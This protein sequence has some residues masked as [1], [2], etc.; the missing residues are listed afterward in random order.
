M[1]PNS[2]SIANVTICTGTSYTPPGGSAETTSGTYITQITNAAGCDSTITTNLL[3]ITASSTSQNIEICKGGSATLP[4]MTVVSPIVNTDYTTTYSSINVPGCDSVITTHVIV[5]QLPVLTATASQIQCT[6]TKGSV[7][8]SASNGT[9]SYTYGGSPTLNLSAGTYNYNVTD[10]KGC[11]GT[12]SATINPAP[13]PL[14][15]SSTTSQISC[16]GNKGSVSLS[17]SGGVSPYV[18]SGSNS[19]NLTAGTYNYTVTD[20]VG[21]SVNLSATINPAPPQLI[22]TATATQIACYLG[23]GSVALSTTGGTPGYVLSGSPTTN[24]STGT[25]NYTVTDSK[26]CTATAFAFIAPAPA[27]L[28]GATSST[29]TRCDGT[30]GTVSITATGGSA[31]YTFLWNTSPAQTTQQAT[32]LGVGTYSVKITD[33]HGCTATASRAVTKALPTTISITGKNT[34]CP[35]EPTSLCATTGLVSYLWNNGDTTRCKNANAAGTY[36]V[37]ATNIS[38]CT[39]TANK[40]LAVGATPVVSITGNDYMCPGSTTVLCATAGFTT[41][42]WDNGLGINCRS[43]TAG[44][45]YSVIVSNTLG[46]T[47]SASRTVK[48]PMKLTSSTVYGIC[49]NGYLG[50]ASIAATGQT[51]PYSYLWSNGSTNQ[52]ISELGAGTYT[53]TVTDSYGCTATSAPTVVVSKLTSDYSTI[54][55]S[56]NSSTIS[57]GANIWF[58]AVMKVNY[59][60]T[61]PVVIKFTNQTIQSS[62]FNLS[63]ANG[64]LILTNSVAQSSTVFNGTEWITTAPPN[65]AGEYFISGYAYPIAL[66]ITANLNPV[67]WKGIWTASCPGV[68]SVEWKWSAAVYSSL[69]ANLDSLG[70]KPVDGNTASPYNNNDLAGTPENYTANLIVGARSTGGINYTG[71]YSGL[72]TR[73]PCAPIVCTVNNTGFV[74]RFKTDKLLNKNETSILYNAFPNP[75]TSTITIELGRNDKTCHT[76]IEIY[77]VAGQKVASVFDQDI[78]KGIKYSVDFNAEDLTGGLYICKIISGDDVISKKLILKK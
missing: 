12:T 27:R 57:L 45:N 41:Y 18:F 23:K 2:S 13:P 33:G 19:T 39:S 53:V 46:C 65:L 55:S 7:V 69:N 9:P 59:I 73:I 28:T 44:G 78:E 21:C 47:A 10:S 11:V 43:I 37:V 61:Y 74:N 14:L 66:A 42:K 8:L 68:S 22:H 62:K 64:K 30:T 40:V 54:N 31:P 56:F 26:G 60:G 1:I 25:Y 4:D 51:G 70:V 50:T 48:T 17:V 58:S 63:P 20:S 24:L 67:S 38:G 75:F 49:S 72:G 5:N 76:T 15:F 77:N 35:G 52:S 71:S 29:T 34:Y 6:G 3:A 36:S 32:G 16:Y